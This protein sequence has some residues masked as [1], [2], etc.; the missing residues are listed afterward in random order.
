MCGL[1][2]WLILTNVNDLPDPANTM[3]R[4]AL[5]PL[6][7]SAQQPPTNTWCKQASVAAVL[8]A[9][10]S[11]YRLS[12]A[13]HMLHSLCLQCVCV[14]V[15]NRR[16]I[17][18]EWVT[19]LCVLTCSYMLVCFTFY[20]QWS[21]VFSHSD[22]LLKLL[23]L[24]EN[25]NSVSQHLWQLNNTHWS[26]LKAN[27]TAEWTTFWFNSPSFKLNN[28]SAVLYYVVNL[29]NTLIFFYIRPLSFLVVPENEYIYIIV[30]F[31][32]EY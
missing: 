10:S 17:W 13:A 14:C 5:F 29:E 12:P 19:Y 31:L 25:G 3:Y 11:R 4:T 9:P 26:S 18:H 2:L 20:W 6:T 15:A 16:E 8:W 23:G 21:W 7:S 30:D 28:W 32:L 22:S 1:Q 27:F 24:W